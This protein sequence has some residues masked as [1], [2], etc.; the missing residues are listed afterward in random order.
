MPY[1]QMPITNDLQVVLRTDG[2]PRGLA[3][4][5]RDE[6]RAMEPAAVVHTVKPLDEYVSASVAYPRFDA[7]LVALFAG[8]ALALAFVGLYGVM[9][10]TV[11]QRTHELG[12]RI[13]LGASRRDVLGLVVGYGMRL[14]A[15]GVVVGLVGAIALTRLIE[16][17]LFGVS[18]TDPLA[19]G[20]VAVALAAVALAAC[21]V[22][23]RRA[24]RVDPVTALRHE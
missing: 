8:V 7:L 20:A 22:P 2:E 14:V 23:A 10:Y 24:S 18:A 15:V 12:V 5:A 17:L 9:S 3:S 13:A 6:V 1:G 4:A 19:F 16:S 21:Y 11:T